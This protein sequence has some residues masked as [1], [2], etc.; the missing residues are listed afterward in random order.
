MPAA[1]QRLRLFTAASEDERIAALEPDDVAP[2]A[3]LGDHQALDLGLRH[4]VVARALADEDAL[5]RGRCERDD[6]IARQARRRATRRRSRALRRPV[7]SA[8]PD[9]P[10]LRRLRTRDPALGG[11]SGRRAW[12]APSS[13][14][15]RRRY[16]ARRA[17]RERARR[18]APRRGRPSPCCESSRITG[19]QQLR[20]DRH[21]HA[22]HE[23]A[24]ALAQ[25][26]GSARRAARPLARE[27]SPPSA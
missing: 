2:F 11:A 9:R 25:A 16:R 12:R 7:T 4:R 8:G 18:R 1:A 3:R 23:H 15:S 17:R 6:R 22:D 20:N 14:R 19:V 10:G 5:A 26:P 27:S 24:F 13:R 21:A